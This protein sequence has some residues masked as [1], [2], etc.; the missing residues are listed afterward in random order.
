MYRIDTTPDFDKDIKSLDSSTA[1][2]IIKK[3]E[4]LACHPDLMKHPMKYLPKEMKSLQKYRV[5]DYRVLFWVDHNHKFIT[6]YGV[7]HRRT[8]YKKL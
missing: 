2:R 6:L 3:I 7:E 8:V 1:S 4:W 5:G